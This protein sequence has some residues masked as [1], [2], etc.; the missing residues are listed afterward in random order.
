MNDTLNTSNPTNQAAV[1][2]AQA[3]N[4]TGNDVT[5][6]GPVGSLSAGQQAPSSADT[7][8][9]QSSQFAQANETKEF[10]SGFAA[11][12]TT[13]EHLLLGSLKGYRLAAEERFK[14][15]LTG[16]ANSTAEA[17]RCLA[18]AENFLANHIA[19]QETPKS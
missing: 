15:L 13:P 8:A 10:V 14:H 12:D 11:E 2:N 9:V 17:L 6:G 5:A 7:A 19:Q 4:A 3:A 18:E 1:Q 16:M